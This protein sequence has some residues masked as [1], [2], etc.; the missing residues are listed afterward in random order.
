MSF[1]ELKPAFFNQ[2]DLIKLRTEKCMHPLISG[3]TSW[4]QVNGRDDIPIP[5]KIEYDAYYMDNKS[6]ILDLK[7]VWMTAVNVLRKRGSKH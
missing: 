6:I 7:I 4:A 5:L 3:I 1:I 2:D